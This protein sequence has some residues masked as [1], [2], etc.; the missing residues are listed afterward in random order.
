MY[1]PPLLEA[2][3]LAKAGAQPQEQPNARHLLDQTAHVRLET[4]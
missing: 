4:G 2:L 3:G 1:M